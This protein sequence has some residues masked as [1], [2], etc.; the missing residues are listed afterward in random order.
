MA[1]QQK[2]Y[3]R[4]REALARC[5]QEHVLRFWEQLDE[6]ERGQLLDDLD[7][8]DLERCQPL[9]ESH[10]K[11]R[12]QAEALGELLPPPSFPAEPG[13]EQKELYARA[14]SV[15]AEAIR[16]GR[17]A[18]FTV[19]GGQGTRLGF[20]GPKGAFKVTPVRGATLFQVFAEQLL[21]IERRY[22]QRPRWYIMTSLANHDETVTFFERNAHFGL[23]PDDVMFFRQGQMP[24]FL[25]DG[26]IALAE[27]HRIALS[28]NG[29]G[30][31]LQ[32]LRDSGALAD[33]AERGVEIISYYQVDNP[34]VRVIDPL[35][36]GLHL[37]TGSEMS[38]K[39]VS[40][41]HDLEK[42]G[43]LCAVGEKVTVIEYSDLPDAL[44]TAKNP[45]GS[46]RFDAGNIAI[47][48]ISR[49]FVE[50]V[51][52][53]GSAIALPW[54]RADK[55]VPTVDDA[56]Q[57]VEPAS[58]NAVKLELFVFDAIPLA[59]NP[60]TLFTQREEEFS[61]VKNAEGTDSPATA[62]R[63]LIRRAARW[64]TA[65]GVEV[66]RDGAGE[67]ALPL[68]ISPAYALDAEDL[69]A[70]LRTAPKLEPGVPTVLE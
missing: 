63:D 69:R 30:G 25:P 32:A 24:A 31:S 34:L 40:K 36:V 33:M 64:L 35:F 38:T 53:P 56:G 49:G 58:P 54:H 26:R 19:A 27:K 66:P 15:G 29:H 42:V 11:Q 57:R 46:R 43:V 12:P 2:R 47:H 45:D 21:G 20:D 39:V 13:A 14:V 22:G 9:I 51:T 1:S 37:E 44:A 7:Q 55:K 62:R 23:R 4:Q 68:E 28:P 10:V 6:A 59:A 70:Q 60:L 5:G 48:A 3:E 8:V 61:P 67:P 65:C 17:V 18:A 52:A 16:A 41:A 50:R